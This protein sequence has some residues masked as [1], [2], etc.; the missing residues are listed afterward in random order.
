M[1]ELQLRVEDAKGR[2]HE[3]GLR[4]P[5]DYPESPPTASVALPAPGS[6]TRSGRAEWRERFAWGLRGLL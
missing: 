1:D 5:P 6:G 4:I 3:L 2:G